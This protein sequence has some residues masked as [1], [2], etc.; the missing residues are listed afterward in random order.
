[1]SLGTCFTRVECPIRTTDTRAKCP[2]QGYMSPPP[3]TVSIELKSIVLIIPRACVRGKA[4]DFVCLSWSR[5]LP[6]PRLGIWGPGLLISTKNLS[7]SA[8]SWLHYASNR[9]T[10]PKSAVCKPSGTIMQGGRKMDI[11]RLSKHANKW[12]CICVVQVDSKWINTCTP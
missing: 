8:K 9:L 6:P 2:L 5:K 3:T 10:R 1:M 11:S 4:I 12:L 7:R